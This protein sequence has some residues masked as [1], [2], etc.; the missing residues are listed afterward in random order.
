MLKLIKPAFLFVVLAGGFFMSGLYIKSEQPDLFCSLI[1]ANPS[2]TQG[3][4]LGMSSEQAGDDQLVTLNE[5]FLTLLGGDQE[6]TEAFIQKH[7]V[8]DI[9]KLGQAYKQQAMNT[10]LSADH[11]GALNRMVLWLSDVVT[12][13][14]DK[15]QFDDGFHV[16]MVTPKQNPSE[17][18]A[19]DSSVVRSV[20][21]EDLYKSCKKNLPSILYD[22][23]CSCSARTARTYGTRAQ[24]TAIADDWSNFYDEATYEK[25]R[26][27]A[28][29]FEK[30]KI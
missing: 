4:R 23:S 6:K 25:N 17:S 2:C 26:S 28:L 9:L 18:G 13:K 29:A 11:R 24:K 7:S 8:A 21:L 14:I 19:D 10:D 5:E 30:C 27:W 20:S 3:I 15:S 1:G 22:Q 16:A 12:Y